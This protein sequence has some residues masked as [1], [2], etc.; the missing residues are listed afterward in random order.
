MYYGR[1]ARA[2]D[3]RTAAAAAVAG[4]WRAFPREWAP[5]L[6]YRLFMLVV[7]FLLWCVVC[8]LEKKNRRTP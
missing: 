6:P 2:R 3:A 4:G 1:R 7:L 5:R 8:F